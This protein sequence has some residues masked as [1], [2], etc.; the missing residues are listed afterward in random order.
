MKTHRNIIA[1]GFLF[2]LAFCTAVMAQEKTAIYVGLFKGKDCDVTI[3]WADEAGPGG[4]GGRIV[5]EKTV[6]LNFTGRNLQDGSLEIDI[7][8]QTHAMRKEAIGGKISW[9][10]DYLS[11]TEV[12]GAAAEK[13]MATPATGVKPPGTLGANPPGT[14]GA[15]P[16]GTLGAKPPGTLGAKPPGTLGAKPP[17]TLGAKPPG[18]LGAPVP[19]PAPQAEILTLTPLVWPVGKWPEGMAHD[20]NFLWVAES[21]QR[22][23]AQIN[24][25]S[26]AV[27]ERVS[28]GRL[29][30]GMASNP[31]TGDVFAAVA[32]D[33]KVVRYSRAAKGGTFASLSDYP[34]SISAD[35]TAVW[36]LMWIDGSNDQSRIVRYDQKSA[37]SIN[38]AFL[39]SGAGN[40][41]KSGNHLW[42]NHTRG[43]ENAMK[44]LVSR[45]DPKTLKPT[46]KVE[47]EG[48]LGGLAATE[49]SVFVC[50][51]NWDVDGAIVRIDPVT[52]KETA[53][54]QIPGEFSYKIA[55]DADYVVV[56]GA[57]GTLWVFSADD[58]TLR[59]TI[60]LDW[61]AY[62]P[63]SLLI[64][65]DVLY[66]AAHA[67]NGEEGS[68]LVLNDW[69]PMRGHP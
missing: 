20:G 32:T 64:V 43:T 67:G 69:A 24:S 16:P 22:N 8:G 26:G 3:N 56:G 7:Q 63:S 9:V 38:S 37:S 10:G 66:I 15:K 46:E 14:L 21:G 39:G 53:R 28:C 30:V 65:G 62:Q 44:T 35:E 54:K 25:D 36:V 57:K 59:R 49:G 12:T 18:T 1:S 68:V 31:V 55:A 45:F 17:G 5:V 34:N 48:Y 52:M 61:K 47:L 6:I 58:L 51:G 19:M 29:P 11:I 41:A 33:Q 40:I 50:G 13:G 4:V 2:I 60:H 42:T 23:L 27:I